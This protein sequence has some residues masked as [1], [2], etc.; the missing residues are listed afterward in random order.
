MT[1]SNLLLWMAQIALLVAAGALLPWVFRLRSAHARLVFWQVLLVACLLLPLLQPW[2]RSV[3]AEAPAASPAAAD[4][5]S[6]V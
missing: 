4:R 1:W 3:V 5:K 2:R 6:V